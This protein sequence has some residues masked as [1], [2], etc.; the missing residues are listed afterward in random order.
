MKQPQFISLRPLFTR[1]LTQEHLIEVLRSGDRLVFEVHATKIRLVD[2]SYAVDL[3]VLE[4]V[5]V[6]V[7]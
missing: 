2:D 7:F 3:F 5:F 4:F 1:I 6:Y